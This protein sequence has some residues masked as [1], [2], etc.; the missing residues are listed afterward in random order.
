MG[1]NDFLANRYAFTL[2]KSGLSEG[3]SFAE[4]IAVPASSDAAHK[5]KVASESSS[6]CRSPPAAFAVL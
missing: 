1:S 4:A 3:R 2:Q 6:A 5:G